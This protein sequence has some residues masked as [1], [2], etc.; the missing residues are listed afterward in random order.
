[1]RSPFLPVSVVPEYGHVVTRLLPAIVAL[2]AACGSVF[3][4]LASG[5][6]ALWLALAS[7]A[8][9]AGF[10]G[11]Y[12]WY[13][14]YREIVF[15][16]EG[17][18]VRRYFFPTVRGSYEEVEGVSPV[19]F[20]LRGFPVVWHT[21][22]NADRVRS[23]VV[24]LVEEDFVAPDEGGGVAQDMAANRQATLLATALGLALWSV[25]ELA[26]LVPAAVPSPLAALG[27]LLVT[28]AAGAPLIKRFASGRRGSGS[29]GD[30][31]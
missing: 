4:V 31:G 18:T 29:G 13:L 6:T 1:M 5:T 23:I 8:V 22:E 17:V 11:L 16:E 27:V 20:R 12:L 24:R 7:F 14:V 15:T 26:G 19:G 2:M 25:L 3:L 28:L 10:L 21:M 9:G 30:A